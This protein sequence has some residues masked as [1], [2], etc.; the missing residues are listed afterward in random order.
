[1]VIKREGCCEGK[2]WE[3]GISRCEPLYILIEQIKKQGPA[4]HTGNCIQYPVI[5]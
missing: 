5:A 4:V 1:M 2:D 3:F